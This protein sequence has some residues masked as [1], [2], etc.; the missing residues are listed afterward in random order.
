MKQVALLRRPEA[1][2]R[3]G[4]GRLG[5]ERAGGSLDRVGLWYCCGAG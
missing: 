3:R 2:R 5:G 4:A 1:E